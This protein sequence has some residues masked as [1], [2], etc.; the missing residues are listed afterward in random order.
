MAKWEYRLVR[1]K[2]EQVPLLG[3]RGK[4]AINEKLNSLVQD[5]WEIV[6]SNLRSVGPGE[7]IVLLLRRE[8]TGSIGFAK[9]EG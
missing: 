2:V 7:Q 3:G 6:D 1:M 5:G 9:E 4:D 8:R